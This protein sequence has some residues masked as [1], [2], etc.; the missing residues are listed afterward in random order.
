MNDKDKA[1]PEAAEPADGQTSVP[2]ENVNDNSGENTAE[3]QAVEAGE[4]TDPAPDAGDSKQG[5][6]TVDLDTLQQRIESLEKEAG[7]Y[8]DQFVRAKAETENIRKRA[9]N[10]VS[11]SRKYAV[12]GF[13]KE[14]LN[15][16]DSL[17]LASNVE[18]DGESSEALQKMQ[19]GL[20]LT[21]KQLDGVFEKFGIKEVEASVG[22]KL[23]PEYHQAMS[24]VDGGE[25]A[26]GCIVNV[27]QAGYT[28]QDRVIRAAMVIVAK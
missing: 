4:S 5:S 25:I 22:G 2:E 23:D 21:L 17:S 11:N 9:E 20:Q 14:V 13:A 7:Q 27:V 6:D 10:E 15:V 12:E 3:A 16:R 18:L 8:K 24:M 26:S 19:E 1:A 28:L